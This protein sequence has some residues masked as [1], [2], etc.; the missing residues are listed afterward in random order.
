MQIEI[1]Q[2][3][4]IDDYL[5]RSGSWHKEGGSSWLAE[6]VSKLGR[7]IEMLSPCGISSL[8]IPEQVT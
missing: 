4:N 3:T 7:E 8:F 2:M 6:A 5:G 1:M